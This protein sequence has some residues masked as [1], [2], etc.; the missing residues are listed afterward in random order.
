[1]DRV[2]VQLIVS[3]C[4]VGA[5]GCPNRRPVPSEPQ[6]PRDPANAIRKSMNVGGIGTRIAFTADGRH[7]LARWEGGSVAEFDLEAAER[8]PGDLRGRSLRA[9]GGGFFTLTPTGRLL[10]VGNVDDIATRDLPDVAVVAMSPPPNK[11]SVFGADLLYDG[12][13]LILTDERTPELHILS[14]SNSAGP[15]RDTAFWT[16]QLSG[17]RCPRSL[18][19]TTLDAS[20]IAPLVAIAGTHEVQLWNVAD[21]QR[22]ARVPAP[23]LEQVLFSP[24]GGHLMIVS[25]NGVRFH[26]VP[27]LEVLFSLDDK[28]TTL[29]RCAR[30]S[31]DGR[32]LALSV[33]GHT[34]AY[35]S[36]VVLEAATG[37]VLGG[38][39]SHFGG[40]VDLAFSPDGKYLASSGLDRFV[41][42]WDVQAI[43]ATQEFKSGTGAERDESSGKPS[44]K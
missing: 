7:L 2:L 19:K 25:H 8:Y 35:G 9:T 17:I 1:V 22:V 43:V 37:R 38:V 40:V 20:P 28:Y 29:P 16:I 24:S 13:P 36:I 34:G 10:F 4:L 39:S 14:T 26:R 3:L 41:R 6:W 32:R 23:Q 5:L 44:S 27:G 21:A 42:I 30:F 12:T 15:P 33:G 31:P 11:L 18:S